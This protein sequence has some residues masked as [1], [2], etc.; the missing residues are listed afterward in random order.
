MKTNK[1]FCLI[2]IL[3][4]NLKINSMSIPV[5][6]FED[7]SDPYL[8]MAEDINY[9]MTEYKPKIVL[10][11]SNFINFLGNNLVVNKV[12]NLSNNAINKVVR[13]REDLNLQIFSKLYNQIA[14]TGS[15]CNSSSNKLINFLLNNFDEIKNLQLSML[16]YLVNQ[17]SLS[18]LRENKNYLDNLT[19]VAVA[20]LRTKE[21][22]ML[23]KIFNQIL[24]APVCKL[25]SNCVNYLKSSASRA[26]RSGVTF[27]GDILSEECTIRYNLLLKDINTSFSPGGDGYNLLTNAENR[28]KRVATELNNLNKAYKETLYLTAKCLTGVIVIYYFSKYLYKYLENKNLENKDN[29]LNKVKF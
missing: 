1:I 15:L 9:F 8:D 23:N 20:R 24:L 13:A 27:L 2:F 19:S 17:V 18:I 26:L 28:F 12:K 11:V 16:P 21:L 14:L 7:Y 29:K 6:Q 22:V 5:N 10:A 4:F 25:K 3:L